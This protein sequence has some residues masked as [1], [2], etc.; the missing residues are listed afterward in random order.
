MEILDTITL[1]LIGVAGLG[2]AMFYVVMGPTIRSWLHKTP[3]NVS[4]T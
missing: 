4:S 3:T 2:A 1:L